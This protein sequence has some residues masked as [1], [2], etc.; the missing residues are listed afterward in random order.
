MRFRMPAVA[1]AVLLCVGVLAMPTVALA[2]GRAPARVP[3]HAA[4]HV[5]AAHRK[6]C[7]GSCRS[8]GPV[9]QV[10]APRH[11][12]FRSPSRLPVVP[13]G[14]WGFDM[15]GFGCNGTSFEAGATP[16]GISHASGLAFNSIQ[17]NGWGWNDMYGNDPCFNAQVQWYQQN[18]GAPDQF[19]MFPVPYDN[20]YC[21]SYSTSTS[22]GYNAGYGQAQ[23]LYNKAVSAGLPVSGG[24]WWLDVEQTSDCGGWNYSLSAINLA[25]IQGAIDFLHS[26][27]LTDGIYTDLGDWN[28]ITNSNKTEFA[29]IPAWNANPYYENPYVTVYNNSGQNINSLPSV[30]SWAKAICG[31]AGFTGGPTT[32]VQYMWGNASEPYYQTD[33]APAIL[34][35]DFDYTCRQRGSSGPPSISS[36][37]GSGAMASTMTINGSNFGGSQSSSYAHLWFTPDNPHSCASDSTTISWGAPGNWGAFTVSSW[38][39]GSVGFQVPTPSGPNRQI[40]SSLGSNLWMIPAGDSGCVNVT[41]SGGTSNTVSFT[42]Q[43]PALY[44]YSSSAWTVGFDGP[45]VYGLRGSNYGPG[46][47]AELVCS[48]DGGQG[49]VDQ[50]GY[51]YPVWDLVDTSGVYSWVWDGEMNTPSG[52]LP[53]HCSAI[54]SANPVPSSI[55]AIAAVAGFQVGQPMDVFGSG[56]GSS[57]GR[58][59]VHLWANNTPGSSNANCGNGS[60]TST[61]WGEP[62]NGAAFTL[63]SW[64]DTRVV[65]G[66][67]T[68]SGPGQVGTQYQIAPATWGCVTIINSSGGTTYAG[69]YAIFVAEYPVTQAFATN[70]VANIRSGPSTADALLWTASAGQSL[71]LICYDPHG[72]SVG[73]YAVWDQLSNGEWVWDSLMTTPPGGPTSLPQCANY[74]P[75]L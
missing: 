27:G 19:I 48:E 32:V 52:G 21:N 20:N 75:N 72:Q 6:L 25:V 5:A 26:K 35:R 23:Q 63:D 56:F 70:A 58:G 47:S 7:R 73:G 61:N 44:N 3:A 65:F 50:Q 37:S 16:A 14:S 31:Q 57:M 68:P 28:A 54:P 39:N 64:S 46:N 29:G 34:G 62:G 45:G 40:G 49:I 10:R 59:Y 60:T 17:L 43:N 41:T 42:A 38:S 66:V 53:A 71:T 36:L 1:L 22:D 33:V 30:L 4:V 18:D 51:N 15:N 13:S 55:N 24:M 69:Q 8:L 2:S 67:P 74:P 9:I 11:L 12:R